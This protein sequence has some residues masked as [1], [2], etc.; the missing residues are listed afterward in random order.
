MPTRAEWIKVKLNKEW[1]I[2]LAPILLGGAILAALIV[3]RGIRAGDEPVHVTTDWSD[4]HVVFSSPKSLLQSLYLGRNP[5]YAQQW[6]RRYAERK[7]D[8][9]GWRAHHNRMEDLLHGDWNAYLGNGG[10]VGAGNY[11]AKYSFNAG[12][13]NCATATQPDFVVYN[14]SLAGSATAVAALTVGTFSGTPG[15][16]Q[17]LVKIGRAH[18]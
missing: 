18:V 7:D 8:W 15:N 13:A 3:V 16:G 14:T 6:L 5:R 1:R 11:P 4:R 9:R 17:T 10:T 2:R 12:T